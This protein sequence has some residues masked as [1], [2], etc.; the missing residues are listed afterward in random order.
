MELTYHIK[1]K[2]PKGKQAYRYLPKKFGGYFCVF[3]AKEIKH[4]VC[5]N[6]IIM[7]TLGIS[8]VAGAGKDLFY[9]I[10]SKYFKNKGL[11]AHR[12]ALA[13][14]LK[15][16]IA[17]ALINL[18]NVN[19]NSCDR[20]VKNLYR[21]MLVFHGK[22]RRDATGGRYWIEKLN[23]KIIA[24]KPNGIVC[25]TDIRYDQYEN[26]EVS[27]VKREMHGLLVH[28]SQFNIVNGEKI[29]RVGANEEERKFDS[30]LRSK[31]DYKIEWERV[32]SSQSNAE[33]ILQKYVEDFLIWFEQNERYR[34][35]VS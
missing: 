30:I 7:I 2:S 6:S 29:F 3:I 1:L 12:Y 8:G 34:Y 23:Q 17:P 10:I 20:T 18:Y 4:I 19:I 13:D 26:D 21:P 22:I 15:K 28:I 35:S 16:E 33:E 5:V 27:W 32:S 24:E 14:E 9:S 25:I 11:Q 31:A